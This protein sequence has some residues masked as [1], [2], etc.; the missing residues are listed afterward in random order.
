MPIDFYRLPHEGIQ[1]I[2][3]YVPGKSIESLKHEQGLTDIIKL[4]SNENPLGCSPLVMETLNKLSKMQLATYP[5]THY[6]PLQ[7]NLSE[8]LGIHE[9][10]LTLSNG[11][12]ALFQLL[13]ITFALHRGKS[14]L[15]HEYAFPAYTIQAQTLGIPTTTIPLQPD[16]RVNIDLLIQASQQ[17]IA[18]LF[19]A[20]PNNPTGL[21]VSHEKIKKLL[22]GVP[23]TTI[24][25]LDEAYYE[26]A[27]CLNDKSSINLIEKHP[28][29]VIT[30]TFSKAYGLAGLRIGYAIANPEI[31]QLLQRVQL[32]FTV[33][34]AALD[35]ANAAIKDIDFIKQS[36]AVNLTGIQTIQ[37][38]LD[39]LELNHLPSS[40]N[41]I[42]FDCQEDSQFIYQCLLK[43]G[44]IVRPLHPN[45][46]PNYIRVTIGNPS[47]NA[48]FLESLS[49]CLKHRS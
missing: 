41:F 37:D 5:T 6:H 33:N 1:L 18:I 40:C 15:T 11:S 26:Y 28:N 8:Q 21:F 34:R 45:G 16:W 43:Q 2:K 29:L 46:L 12:D 19:I 39:R 4:A 44:I 27:Y 23:E 38:G 31:T 17:N 22:L 7:I 47:Q 9:N 20:N 32:P 36:L 35:A 3:P 30:R 49:H 48:R 10:Q 25:V 13:L 14:I 42:T 24:V